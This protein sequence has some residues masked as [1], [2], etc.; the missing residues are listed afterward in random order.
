MEK[1]V[2]MKLASYTKSRVFLMKFSVP[3]WLIDG[4]NEISV[5]EILM[6]QQKGIHCKMA[7]G[8]C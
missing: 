6:P 2:E 5:C 7:M 4:E 3:A 8:F 1:S